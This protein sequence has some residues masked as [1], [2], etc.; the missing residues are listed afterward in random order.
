NSSKYEKEFI[1]CEEQIQHLMAGNVCS[2]FSHIQQDVFATFFFYIAIS[3]GNDTSTL[4]F[5]AKVQHLLCP[6]KKKKREYSSRVC[7][8]RFKLTSNLFTF[9]TFVSIPRWNSRRFSV[10][11][12]K[13]FI[14]FKKE[15]N[16]VQKPPSSKAREK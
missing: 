12:M 9:D 11:N 1:E 15:I 10:G 16:K 8:H 4:F 6:I 2:T 14:F 5:F 7:L 3:T 13:I